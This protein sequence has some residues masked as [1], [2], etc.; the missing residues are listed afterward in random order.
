VESLEQRLVLSFCDGLSLSEFSPLVV[1]ALD[2]CA[3]PGPGQLTFG[4]P[5]YRIRENAGT[6][7]ILIVRTGGSD[8]GVTVDY[9]TSDGTATAGIDY[10]SASGTL[11]FAPGE[12]GKLVRIPILDDSGDEG[13]A[14][15]N[16]TLSNAAGGAGLGNP[17]TAVLTILETSP[18]VVAAGPGMAVSAAE[19]AGF[20]GQAVATFTDP[21]SSVPDAGDPGGTP[22]TATIDWGDGTPGQPDV[23]PGTI[24]GPDGSGVFTVRGDH[25]YAEEGSYPV[26]TTI[27]YDGSPAATA[28]TTVLV[29]DPAV[30]ATAL[31]VSATEGT[32]FT[33]Q[34]VATFTDAGGAEPNASDVGGTPYTA[35][36][37]WGDGSAASTG[38][39]SRS[40]D[41]F[42]VRGSH[43]YAATGQY[44]VTT[45]IGHEGAPAQVVTGTATVV[46]PTGPG[47]PP[48]GSPAPELTD[49]TG[50][51]GFAPG[52]IRVHPV[53]RR[54]RVRLQISNRSGNAIQGPLYLVLENL[55]RN[56]RLR[57]PG[58]FTRTHLTAGSPYRALPVGAKGLFAPGQELTLV[59][60]FLN[61][62]GRRI[63]FT[64]HVLAGAGLP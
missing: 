32:G 41:L 21:G 5:A 46:A 23:T 24:S 16:L 49:I 36:I 64:P 19:G 52:G 7:T 11:T 25:T 55:P 31:A 47:A 54:A 35:T 40:G 30:R 51:V 59:L 63:R 50:Q 53:G 28:T 1:H 37:D 57:G 22:Y 27:H 20:T 14:T 39:I 44:T 13:N 61:P 9:G 43:A 15:V 38:T 6:A 17:S 10:T 4:A 56:V 33:G 34:A 62:S 48:P 29:T 58:G 12:M 42:T 45:T 18:P 60:D 26:T 3:P 8:G 2:E